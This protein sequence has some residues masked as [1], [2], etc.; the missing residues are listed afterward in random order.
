MRARVCAS[1]YH[2]VRT[3]HVLFEIMAHGRCTR[4]TYTMLYSIIRVLD[5]PYTCS[6]TNSN[7]SPRKTLSL[8]CP[9]RTG[10]KRDAVPSLNRPRRPYPQEMASTGLERSDPSSSHEM[11]QMV[12]AATVPKGSPQHLLA[13]EQAAAATLSSLMPYVSASSGTSQPSWVSRGHTE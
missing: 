12:V 3:V 9:L 10:D 8:E 11:P 7:W 6:A 4:C 13:E 2:C 5:I 1:L